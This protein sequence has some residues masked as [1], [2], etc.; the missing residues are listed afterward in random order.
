MKNRNI[1][2]ILPPRFKK[3]FVSISP[4]ELPNKI[5]TKSF[6]TVFIGIVFIHIIINLYY[7]NIFILLE[8]FHITTVEYFLYSFAW[9]YLMIRLCNNNYG[10]SLQ[11]YLV[12]NAIETNDS[13]KSI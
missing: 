1:I 8:Y 12:V 10:S 11:F 13:L 2:S 6:T 3:I 5:S 4:C 9:L 7:N